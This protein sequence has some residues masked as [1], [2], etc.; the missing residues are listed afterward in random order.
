MA[1]SIFGELQEPSGL[2]FSESGMFAPVV[3]PQK[4]AASGCLSVK[5]C[6]FCSRLFYRFVPAAIRSP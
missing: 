6:V 1:D 2:T 3:H 5:L 4:A